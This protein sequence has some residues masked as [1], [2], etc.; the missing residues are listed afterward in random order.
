MDNPWTFGWTQALTIVGFGITIA[1]ARAGF[2]SFERWRREKVEERRIEAA[3]DALVLVREMKWVFENIRSPMTFD[4]EW[5]D[6]PQTAGDTDAKRSKRGGYFA[7]LSRVAHHKDFFDRA[8]KLQILCGALF[9]QKAEDALLT[10]QKARRR[11]EVSAGMLTSNPEPEVRSKDNLDTWEGF[12]I[13]VW[14]HYA[15][16]NHKHDAVAEMI[17]GVANQVEAICRPALDRQLGRRKPG[18]A[19]VLLGWLGFKSAQ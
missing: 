16:T 3:I 4:Y 10:L 1:I 17:E 12:R 5:K 6:M 13:D 7:I 14:A 11:V 8:W 18:R 2:R 19:R 9:G 15:D